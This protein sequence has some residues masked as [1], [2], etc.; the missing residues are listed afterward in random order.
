MYLLSAVT[1]KQQAL[2]VTDWSRGSPSCRLFLPVAV[3]EKIPR[4]QNPHVMRKQGRQTLKFC[5]K[6]RN[7]HGDT[8]F[9]GRAI[10]PL[11]K[12]RKF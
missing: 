5:S 4:K 1:T 7:E 10:Y 6:N 11:I 3:A 9:K 12:S 2:G 8:Y